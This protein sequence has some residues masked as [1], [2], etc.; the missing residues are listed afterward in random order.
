MLCQIVF[1]S[2]IDTI[3]NISTA[4]VLFSASNLI[5]RSTIGGSLYPSKWYRS[6]VARRMLTLK[7]FNTSI[8]QNRA[9][10][11]PA[12]QRLM[13]ELICFHVLLVEFI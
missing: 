3:D 8:L 6:G 12:F 5:P 10:I 4:L 9:I 7:E 13:S 11:N 2:F 1:F